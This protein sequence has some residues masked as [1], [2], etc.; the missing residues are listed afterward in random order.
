MCNEVSVPF[1]SEVHLYTDPIGKV[2]KSDSV[3]KLRRLTVVNPKPPPA[4]VKLLTNVVYGW[5]DVMLQPIMCEWIQVALFEHP[6]IIDEKSP[7]DVLRV[8]PPTVE[9]KPTDVLAKPPD[10]APLVD[11]E[12][13][14]LA[15]PP[16]I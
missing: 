13:T 8:P 11:G 12:V 16:P 15:L 3:G 2:T 10:T 7:A 6:P 14:A 4:T 9:F 1:P 5:S